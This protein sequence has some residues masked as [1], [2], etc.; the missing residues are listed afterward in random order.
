MTRTC[1][2]DGCDNPVP[3]PAGKVGRPPIYCSP[4]CRPSR[5]P[6]A[7]Y[8]EAERADNGEDPSR[9]WEVR[10]RR[11]TRVVVLQ[12]GLGRFSATALA[13]DVHALLDGSP[14]HPEH[15]GGTIE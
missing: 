12:R 5:T 3:R 11:G 10:L 4:A 6:P 14:T 8:A 2:A 7:V 9:D 13:A 1:A 15:R